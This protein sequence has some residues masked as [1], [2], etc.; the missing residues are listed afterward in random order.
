MSY[1]LIDLNNDDYNTKYN[2]DNIIIGKKISG[3]DCEIS[4]HYI[5]YKENNDV[6]EIYLKLPS[7]RLIY[8]S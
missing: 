1:Y 6:K 3:G 4:K 8:N 7:F 5:Y 2:F